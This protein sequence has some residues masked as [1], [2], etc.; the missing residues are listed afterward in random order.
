MIPSE[1]H[2]DLS[3]EGFCQNELHRTI[4]YCHGLYQFVFSLL[5]ENHSENIMILAIFHSF[6]PHIIRSKIRVRCW[7]GIAILWDRQQW[8]MRITGKMHCRWFSYSSMTWCQRWCCWICRWIKIT[9]CMEGGRGWNCFWG[10]TWI[11]FYWGLHCWWKI[12]VQWGCSRTYWCWS[13][14]SM[15]RSNFIRRIPARFNFMWGIWGIP[16]NMRRGVKRWESVGGRGIGIICWCWWI[17]VFHFNRWHIKGWD[18]GW[19]IF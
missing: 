8:W 17:I 14:N 16:V 18:D 11:I 6:S 3:L 2:L 10:S 19:G 5:E 4:F 1:S 9:W 7:Y 15:A 12:W 13:I